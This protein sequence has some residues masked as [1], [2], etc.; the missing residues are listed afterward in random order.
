MSWFDDLKTRVEQSS[1][2]K[3]IGEY[4][5]GR[6]VEEVVKVVKPPTGNLTPLEIAQGRVGSP[7]ADMVIQPS[8]QYQQSMG[9]MNS[10]SPGMMLGIAAAGLVAVYF[11][12][13]K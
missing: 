10:M 11:L 4:L 6:A 1:E 8:T 9:M 7:P 12:V 3:E 2:Y 13:R 5:R